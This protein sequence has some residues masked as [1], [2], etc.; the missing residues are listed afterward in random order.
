[1]ELVV[2]CKVVHVMSEVQYFL[3]K[4]VI[5]VRNN[6]GQHTE[7]RDRDRRHNVDAAP[8]LL[9]TPQTQAMTAIGLRG[10]Y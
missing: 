10:M 5:L 1:V 9:R 8:S 3:G 2:Q 4:L 6:V 7:Y